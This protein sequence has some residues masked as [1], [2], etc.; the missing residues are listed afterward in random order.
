MK[1]TTAKSNNAFVCM[2]ECCML[3]LTGFKQLPTCY[4]KS[5]PV[6]NGVAATG[7]LQKEV[8]AN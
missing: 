1:S 6:N 2:Y 3:H 4:L 7:S 5:G 8:L